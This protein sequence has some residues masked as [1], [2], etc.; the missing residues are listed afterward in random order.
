MKEMTVKDVEDMFKTLRKAKLVTGRTKVQLSCDEEGND[1][2]P[3]AM[4]DNGSYNVSVD[5]EE[6]IITLYPVQLI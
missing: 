5:K 1:F 3:F 2:S 6:N 4:F